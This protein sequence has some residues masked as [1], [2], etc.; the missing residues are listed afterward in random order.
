MAA[1]VA[2][3]DLVSTCRCR[4]RFGWK[5]SCC[6]VVSTCAR[7]EAESPR[8]LGIAIAVGASCGDRCWL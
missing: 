7:G 4:A 8:P 5:V 6:H 3:A 2:L 1:S